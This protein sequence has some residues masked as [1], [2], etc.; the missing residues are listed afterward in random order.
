MKK[1]L[2]ALAALAATASF[3]QSAVTLYGTLDA[4]MISISNGNKAV[5]GTAPA[6]SQ[7]GVVYADSAISSSV[8]GLRGSED[9]G[10]GMKAIFNVEGDIQ[11]NNGGMNHNGIFR[12]A[13][14]VGL[15]GNFGIVE[16]GVK[17]N[18]LIA[19]NGALAPLGGNSVMT[20]TASS[21][22]YADFYTKNAITYTTPTISGFTGQLQYGDSNNLNSATDGSVT[23]YS[24]AY[25][26]GPLAIRIAGQDRKEAAAGTA[27]SGANPTTPAAAAV[28]AAGLDANV[29]A[30]DAFAKRTQI[31]GAT[32][33]IGAWTLGGAAFQN[34]A[35]TALGGALTK[36]TGTLV[37]ASYALNSA[38]TLGANVVNSEGSTLTNAQARYALSKRT[39]VYT[40]LGSAKNGTDNR[41]NFYPTATN[42]GTA[43]AANIGNAGGVKDSNQS[44]IGFGIIHTF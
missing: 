37:G 30:K 13:A 2:V 16:L 21:L 19:T 10:G 25:V 4:S 32:Y 23:A 22:G 34:E 35:A 1:T 41:V 9:L 27:D 29:A 33:T 17:V 40:Q 18:P 44:S 36:V 38:V 28:T 42:T 43:P 15:S 14:N 39:T 12:R 20:S 11:T 24:L 26:N 5:V 6:A 8:W 31:M 7:S 3:A